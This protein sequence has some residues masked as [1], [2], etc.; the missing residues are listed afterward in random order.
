MESYQ[1]IRHDAGQ[2]FLLGAGGFFFLQIIRAAKRLNTE[3]CDLLKT[4][5]EMYL[6]MH[7]SETSKKCKMFACLGHRHV[8]T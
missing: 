7:I 5:D 3:E 4:C 6:T 8:S 1:N 2:L